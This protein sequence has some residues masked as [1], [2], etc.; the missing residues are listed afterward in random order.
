[1]SSKTEPDTVDV[2]ATASNAILETIP[3]IAPPGVL[4]TAL[5]KYTGANSD[6]ATLS[7][8]EKQLYVTNGNLNCIAVVA[9]TGTNSGDQVVGLIPTGWY[10]NSVS[11]STD[12]SWVYTVNGKSPTGAN[13][14]FCYSAGAP[15]LPNC[16]LANQYNPQLTKA[17][18]QTFPR[19][20]A[21]QL[22]TLT[23]QVAVNNRFS[24]TES[25]SD[26]AVM[27]AVRAG[28][29]HV[30]FILKENRAY[31]QIL[32]DLEVGNG[33]PDLTEFGQ[34]VTPNAHNLAL[35]FVTLDNFYGDRRSEQ[36]RLALEHCRARAGRDRA[37]VSGVLFLRRRRVTRTQLGLRGCE[38]QRERGLSDTRRAPVYA[39]PFTPNDPDLLPGQTDVAAPDGPD[40]EI[41]TGYLWDAALRANLTVRNYGFFVDETRY[42]TTTN[43]IPLVE[44][45]AADG[46]VVSYPTNVALAPRTDPY[47]RGFDNA[48]P[49]YYRYAE[50]AREFDNNYLVPA[51]RAPEPRKPDS[52]PVELPRAPHGRNHPAQYGDALPEPGSFYARSHRQFQR[53]HRWREHSGAASGR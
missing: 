27:A 49:D 26:A 42:N 44:N 53:R 32:G 41:N 34:A 36:R 52:A 7:P 45:P 11:F 46:I 2:I 13:P 19:P 24:S 40:N 17:G 37:P 14:G 30:I 51:C 43:T 35:N 20:S 10:P 50:W 47:F 38:S 21:A 12:G 33:D 9:L 8:D 18:F 3:V 5:A 25:P 4:P 48:F 1:M 39:D 29:Q 6:S 22:T 16:L 15:T 31:D 28:V 23:A